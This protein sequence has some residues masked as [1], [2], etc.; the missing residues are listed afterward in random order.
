[1]ARASSCRYCCSLDLSGGLLASLSSPGAGAQRCWVPKG[2][3]SPFRSSPMAEM[4]RVGKHCG[5]P[6][7]ALAILRLQKAQLKPYSYTI[8]WL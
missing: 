5:T 8:S 3:A 2:E 6:K 4:N 7:N 1:M